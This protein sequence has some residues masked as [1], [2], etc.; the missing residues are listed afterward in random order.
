MLFINS[1]INLYSDLEEL[2]RLK[3][4]ALVDISVFFKITEEIT[5]RKGLEELYVSIVEI[6]KEI[7]EAEAASLLLYHHDDNLLSFKSTTDE[8]MK[9]MLGISIPENSGFAWNVFKVY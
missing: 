6:S 3:E 5:P 7:L 9:K 4:H 8:G 2:K 1:T